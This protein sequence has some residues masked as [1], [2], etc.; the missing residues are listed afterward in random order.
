MSYLLEF[1]E[2]DS[3]CH[4]DGSVRYVDHLG[5]LLF[6]VEVQMNLWQ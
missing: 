6:Q 5:A 3:A 2:L 1:W 4:L